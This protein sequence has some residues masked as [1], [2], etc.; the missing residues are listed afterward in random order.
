MFTL[1]T[2][3]LKW[4]I[5]VSYKSET[6]DVVGQGILGDIADLGIVGVASVRT[7]QIYWIEGNI[8]SL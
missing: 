6:P 3:R 2:S 4:K 7:A 1:E 8:N 5:E